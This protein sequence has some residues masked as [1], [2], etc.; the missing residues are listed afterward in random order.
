[1]QLLT[2]IENT[3]KKNFRRSNIM[4]ILEGFSF[5]NSNATIEKTNK[6]YKWSSIYI[7]HSYSR[8]IFNHWFFRWLNL[9]LFLFKISSKQNES[10][11]MREK[12]SLIN[13]LK[14]SSR[15]S[16]SSY[17]YFLSSMHDLIHL[18]QFMRRKFIDNQM[19][20]RIS[21]LLFHCLKIEMISLRF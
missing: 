17:F 12:I 19:T 20:I 14:K 15:T 5:L 9:L 1:M 7:L 11:R 2:S 18:I 3:C 16:K 6:K 21:Q 8:S 4:Y 10:P 13:V